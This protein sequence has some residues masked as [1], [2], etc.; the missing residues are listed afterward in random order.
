MSPTNFGLVVGRRPGHQNLRLGHQQR[1]EAIASALSAMM[2]SRSRASVAAARCRV[3][4]ST[5]AVTTAK[6]STPE[7][8]RQGRDLVA[9]K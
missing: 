6:N 3:R 7:R 1:V 5:I 8:Q 9:V 2:W 4:T